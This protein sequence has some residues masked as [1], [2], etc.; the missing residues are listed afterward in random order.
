[1][2]GSSMSFYDRDI[3]QVSSD[4]KVIHISY[5]NLVPGEYEKRV[6]FGNMCSSLVK[7][8]CIFEG[9]DADIF[10]I[11]A[12]L[13]RSDEYIARETDSIQSFLE[14]V[15]NILKAVRDCENYLIP[16][17]EI[18]L[19]CENIFF[20]EMNGSVRLMY[21]PGFSREG[22][23]GR[24]VVMI[25]EHAEKLCRFGMLHKDVLSEYRNGILE[26]ENDIQEMISLTEEAMRRTFNVYSSD[27]NN[28]YDASAAS[29]EK[30]A[31][32]QPCGSGQSPS[33]LPAYGGYSHA[34]AAASGKRFAAREEPVEYGTGGVIK[35][36]IRE[37]IN[38]LVS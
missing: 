1:M 21:L 3:R 22:T 11:T 10:Y 16:E 34:D 8:R 24:E 33:A 29:E 15:L 2:M 19:R 4:D 9:N 5:D 6:I 35:K 13:S 36:H 17:N 30:S 38:E 26:N 7:M 23:I 27:V 20:S 32:M 37:F 31:D 18:S 14:M 28:E 12:G 25:T